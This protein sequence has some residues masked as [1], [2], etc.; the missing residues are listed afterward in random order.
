MKDATRDANMT[1]RHFRRLGVWH[2]GPFFGGSTK[3]AGNNRNWMGGMMI[4][5]GCSIQIVFTVSG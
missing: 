2:F 1:A 5:P 3:M 4:W